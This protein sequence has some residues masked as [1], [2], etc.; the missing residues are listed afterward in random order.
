M[1]LFSL[2]RTEYV[3]CPY[4]EMYSLYCL[5]LVLVFSVNVLRKGTE[6]YV[7]KTA[8]SSRLLLPHSFRQAS[9]CCNVKNM[10]TTTRFRGISVLLLL[11]DD[12]SLNPGM[13]FT[14]PPLFQGSLKK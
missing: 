9:C 1:V 14:K 13:V 3:H 4:S 11:C 8:H 12:I 5:I 7:T 10:D 6:L 2:R